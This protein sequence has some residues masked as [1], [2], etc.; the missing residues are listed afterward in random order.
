MKK[1]AKVNLKSQ[2]FTDLPTLLKSPDPDPKRIITDPEKK[3]SFGSA[4][5]RIQ[6]TVKIS[7]QNYPM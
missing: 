6:N 3:K 2:I 5:I 4:Q 1:C 7:M